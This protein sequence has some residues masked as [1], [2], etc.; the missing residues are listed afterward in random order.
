MA[1]APTFKLVIVGDGGVGKTTLMKRL[2]SGFEARYIPTVGAE[3]HPIKFTTDKGQVIFNTWNTAGQ[4]KFG[5]LKDGFFANS[6]CGIIMFDV[7]SRVSYKNV[8]MWYRDIIRICK[9]IPI[10]LVGNKV[11]IKE[12][13]VKAKAITFHR[14]RNLLYYDVST[15]SNYNIE[16]PFLSLARILLNDDNLNLI[17]PALPPPEVEVDVALMKQYSDELNAAAAEPVAEDDF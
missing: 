3:V 2:S 15:K 17:M 5:G 10:I 14:K 11:D 8:P 7:T 6:Q 1:Q 13:H 4:E 12:R 9:E 16:K